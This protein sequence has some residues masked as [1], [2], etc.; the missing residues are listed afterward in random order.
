[1]EKTCLASST[2]MAGR[3]GEQGQ[4]ILSQ[5]LEQC[6]SFSNRES[7]GIGGPDLAILMMLRNVWEA[8]M[9][10]GSISRSV[11]SGTFRLMRAS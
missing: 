10:E 4:D 5:S 11:V 8:A 6:L 1:M 7:A 2:V 9:K 3:Y